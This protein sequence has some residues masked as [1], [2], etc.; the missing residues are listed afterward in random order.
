M[1][2]PFG[3]LLFYSAALQNAPLEPFGVLAVVSGLE[4]SEGL[5]QLSLKLADCVSRYLSRLR[6]S[7]LYSSVVSTWRSLPK[8]PILL[9]CRS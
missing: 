6:S 9:I 3:R 2:P 7:T 8:F 4:L 1:E 5:E